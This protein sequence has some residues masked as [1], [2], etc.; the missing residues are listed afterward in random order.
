M[1]ENQFT[2]SLTCLRA[3]CNLDWS[4]LAA[5]SFAPMHFAIW[6]PSIVA[7]AS[8]IDIVLRQ[9]EPCPKYVHQSYSSGA[10]ISRGT[11]TYLHSARWF[12]RISIPLLT[13][14]ARRVIR[15]A[16]KMV[17]DLRGWKDHVVEGSPRAFHP[18]SD[19]EVLT[20]CCVDEFALLM[21]L[22]RKMGHRLINRETKSGAILIA[23]KRGAPTQRGY[24]EK[25]FARTR[26]AIGAML[27][28]VRPPAYPAPETPPDATSAGSNDP[29]R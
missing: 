15:N 7:V 11:G 6:S 17:T 21:R 1:S 28:A 8:V 2:E 23:G 20:A 22:T 5:K 19:F 29:T 25:E 16:P 18:K 13:L 3:R 26:D 24:F 27:R 10:D 14:V 9:E 12:G 4:K